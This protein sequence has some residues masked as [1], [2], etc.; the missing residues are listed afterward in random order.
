MNQSTGIH[1]KVTCNDQMRRFQLS[2]TEFSSLQDQVIKLLGLDREFVLKYKDNEND[3]ITISSN[4]ELACAIEIS[5]NENAGLFR[6]TVFFPEP[7]S[8]P[9]FHIPH[10]HHHPEHGRNICHRGPSTHVPFRPEHGR[11]FCHRAPPMHPE[12][13]Q[14]FCHRGHGGK[15]SGRRCHEGVPASPDERSCMKNRFEKRRA[16][17][18][19]KRD[20]LK[21]YLNSMELTR[22]L[23]P[24]EEKRKQ[25]LLSRV[26]RLD[27]ILAEFTPPPSSEEFPGERPEFRFRRDH[28]YRKFE[29]RERKCGKKE[30]KER[31][32][33]ELKNSDLSDE[34]KAEISTLKSQIKEMK[35]TVW[36]IKEQLRVKK[37][38]IRVAFEAGD[39]AKIPDL[40]NDIWK[41]KQEKRA[42]IEQIKPL[43]NRVHQL[44]SGK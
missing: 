17:M 31:K 15:W 24:E 38:A 43:K 8:V 20:M 26:Q 28:C 33:K 42:K 5:R 40:K 3:M 44:K 14:D 35:P 37:S 21:T 4:E 1:C 29:K 23:S 6:L 7:S 22:D 41:L 12:H 9:S 13:E 2:C 30:H 10:H 16:K 36:A 18:T 34:A 39:Q 19:L 25:H 32:F 27:S 11:N